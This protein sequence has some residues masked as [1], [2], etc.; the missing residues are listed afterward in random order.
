MVVLTI[1][2]VAIVAA[3]VV[4]RGGGEGGQL[5]RQEIPGLPSYISVDPWNDLLTAADIPSNLSEQTQFEWEFSDN[6]WYGIP[7]DNAAARYWMDS[8]GEVA[9]GVMGFVCPTEADARDLLP[10][11]GE[12]WETYW[13]AD[14]GSISHTSFPLY[15]EE[16]ESFKVTIPGGIGYI[17]NFRMQNVVVSV[18]ATQVSKSE[19]GNYCS[20]VEQRI[21][22]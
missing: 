6:Y 20:L 4:L 19:T 7:F 21:Y 17:I 5:E 9:V 8:L 15:G 13:Q 1:C 2:A 10:L 12:Y 22:S 16:R 11:I 18:I 3:I 14:G